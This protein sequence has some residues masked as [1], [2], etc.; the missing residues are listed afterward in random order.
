[1]AA[2]R[3]WRFADQTQF[4]YQFLFGRQT[5]LR[6]LDDLFSGNQTEQ[7]RAYA[8]AGAFVRD[9]LQRYG[10]EA[11]GRILTQVKLGIPFNNA[12]ANISGRTPAIAETEFWNGQKI[13]TTW[14]P[15]LTSSAA[16][17][18]V[19]TMLA[20]FAIRRRRIKDAEFRKRWEEEE[21]EKRP[22]I[23]DGPVN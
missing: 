2:E 8:L 10:S 19:V 9:L 20:L 5:S 23:E 16:L 17:W 6:A 1:M 4:L 15:V 3:A 12:F 14:V 21:E 18:M 11:G 13:W 7:T 22:S